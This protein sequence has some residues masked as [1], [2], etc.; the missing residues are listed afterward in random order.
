MDDRDK[1]AVALMGMGGGG[2]IDP[3]LQVAGIGY[4]GMPAGY[5]DPA[6]VAQLYGGGGFGGGM[7]Q[8]A[9][10]PSPPQATPPPPATPQPA[11]PPAPAAP[12]PFGGYNGGFSGMP[13]FGGGGMPQFGGGFGGY[14]DPNSYFS[15]I[16][17]GIAPTRDTFLN[18]IMPAYGLGPFGPSFWEGSRGD[19]GGGG[20]E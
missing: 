19:S 1:I 9:P 2:Y 20:E 10:A 5:V 3:A 8:Q 14:F 11:P 6:M 7:P 12:L 13:Q 15:N 18:G 16:A 4:G 17:N